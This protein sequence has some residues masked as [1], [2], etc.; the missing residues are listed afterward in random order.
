MRILLPMLALVCSS[1]LIA[2][3]P[4][5]SQ[6]PHRPFGKNHDCV[7]AELQGY[8]EWL[9]QDPF[10]RIRRLPPHRYSLPSL[11]WRCGTVVSRYALKSVLRDIRACVYYW[12]ENREAECRA[13]CEQARRICPRL[14]TP[15]RAGYAPAPPPQSRAECYYRCKETCGRAAD[16]EGIMGNI[17]VDPVCMQ[18][19]SDKCKGMFH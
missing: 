11:Q 8:V 7:C 15:D 2:P 18:K 5:N 14:V 1:A 13:A 17:A 9:K 12:A 3:E 19:C 4:G 10:K 16:P 6:A